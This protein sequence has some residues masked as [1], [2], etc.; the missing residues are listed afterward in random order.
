MTDEPFGRDGEIPL[1][2]SAAKVFK[3]P[4]RFQTIEQALATAPMF[5]ADLVEVESAATTAAKSPAGWM[6]CGGADGWAVIAMAAIILLVKTWRNR[7]R[8]RPLP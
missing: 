8:R 2:R 4:A 3:G 5:Y 7:D 1:T 6:N